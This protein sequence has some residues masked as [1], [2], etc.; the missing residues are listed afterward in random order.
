MVAAPEEVEVICKQCR[1]CGGEFLV[2][3]LFKIGNAFKCAECNSSLVKL[4][5]GFGA[6]PPATMN[7]KDMARDEQLKFFQGLRGLKSTKD[8]VVKAEQ[9]MEMTATRRK[10]YGKGGKFM[11]LK[12]WETKG[13]DV[14]RIVKNSKPEDVDFDD[15]AGEVYRVPIRSEHDWSAVAVSKTA[16]C[17][18]GTRGRDLQ[19][20]RALD[21][22]ELLND[23]EPEDK[24]WCADDESDDDVSDEEKKD[25]KKRKSKKKGKKRKKS[26]S[27]SDDA[28]SSSDSSS[29]EKKNKRKRGKQARKSGSKPSGARTS[30]G[31]GKCARSAIAGYEKEKKARERAEA[32][33]AKEAHKRLAADK[34]LAATSIPKLAAAVADIEAL[35]AGPLAINVPRAKITEVSKMKGKLLQ[36]CEEA[37]ECLVNETR[38]AFERQDVNNL[39]SEYKALKATWNQIVAVMKKK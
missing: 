12:Y 39:L 31:K 25:K 35:L 33:E 8:V 16:S 29:S 5:K 34:T 20:M 37:K 14:D 1:Y 38:L 15:V 22:L 3:R 36:K 26:S 13:Y 23:L 17:S 32:K 11:P 18:G 7:F 2:S 28:S 19:S 4:R 24:A 27:S 21:A 6:W 10:E 9:S 30:G